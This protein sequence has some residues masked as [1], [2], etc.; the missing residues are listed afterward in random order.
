P[1]VP[2]LLGGAAAPDGARARRLRAFLSPCADRARDRSRGLPSCAAGRPGQ[3]TEKVFRIG[4]VSDGA[5]RATPHW[6][7]F[8]RRL[9]ELGY[10]EGRTVSIEFRNAEGYP[11]RFPDSA[12]RAAL[13]TTSNQHREWR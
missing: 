9:S 13:P 11:E 1:S 2:G 5:P 6:T 4:A 3:P 7:A 10:V 12:L 8:A